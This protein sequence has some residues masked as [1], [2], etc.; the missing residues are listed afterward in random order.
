MIPLAAVLTPV[1]VSPCLTGFSF[2]IFF[3]FEQHLNIK[4]Q[5]S[6]KL[7]FRPLV[8]PYT[9]SLGNLCYAIKINYHIGRW[10]MTFTSLN[11]TCSPI[12]RLIKIQVP[13]CHLPLGISVTT[14]IQSAQMKLSI[15]LQRQLFS[16]FLCPNIC[17]YY[18]IFGYAT[19]KTRK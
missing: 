3:F 10:H 2:T 17:Y 8:S 18:H 12:S 15:Y 13:T 7:S 6:S 14:Q 16:S 11:L 5:R 9:L 19:Q 4:Y 1:L